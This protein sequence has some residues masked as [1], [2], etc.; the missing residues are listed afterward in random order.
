MATKIGNQWRGPA[1]IVAGGPAAYGEHVWSFRKRPRRGRARRNSDFSTLPGDPPST[2]SMC[3]TELTPKSAQG[4]GPGACRVGRR[5]Q[6]WKRE[7][8]G[9]GSPRGVVSSGP[10]PSDV[11]RVRR[12]AARSPERGSPG[13]APR[14]WR[15]DQRSGSDEHRC[16]RCE[17]SQ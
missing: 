10:S 3:P 9:I 13:N 5:G 11:D 6:T 17:L 12:A 4:L 15:S 14:N 8:L 2:P 16:H 7:Q 1:T